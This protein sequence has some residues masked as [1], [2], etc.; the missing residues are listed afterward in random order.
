MIRHVRVLCFLFLMGK[1]LATVSAY[2]VSNQKDF[3]KVLSHQICAANIE[4]NE[5]IWEEKKTMPATEFVLSWN[6]S[7]PKQGYYAFYVRLKRKGWTDWRK[8]AEWGCD[9][10]RSFFE[11]RRIE[12]KIRLL[13]EEARVITAFQ[14]KIVA[15]KGAL[16]RDVDALHASLCYEEKCRLIRP[17][18]ILDSVLVSG[19]PRQ[20]QMGLHIERRQ[21]QRLCSPTS[22]SMVL[23][24][25]L[26]DKG[27]NGTRCVVDPLGFAAL[28]YDQGNDIYGNWALNVAAAYDVGGGK[29]R[30]YVAHLDSFNQIYDYLLQGTPVVVSV[31]GPLRGG[32]APYK[33]GHLLVV[34]GWEKEGRKIICNDPAFPS[35]EQTFV[36]Y[37]SDDFIEAWGRRKNVCYLIEPR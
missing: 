21:A 8:S 37:D 35:N 14:V 25:F 33:A 2:N 28:A 32:A 13:P 16:I 26:N 6:A 5:Y 10:Q 20:S 17:S 19:V 30:S 9:R 29:V 4:G 7:R 1:A 36:R 22:T 27:K 12:Q 11:E 23:S 31:K 18:R 15:C 24:Y 34:V 3:C